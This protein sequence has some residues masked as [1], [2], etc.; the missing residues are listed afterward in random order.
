MIRGILF[1]MLAAYVLIALGYS[2]YLVW[3]QRDAHDLEFVIPQAIER[4]LTWPLEVL[5]K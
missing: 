3:A 2:G 5:N 4:G 1:F